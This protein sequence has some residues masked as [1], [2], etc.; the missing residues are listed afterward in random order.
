MDALK[1]LLICFATFIIPMVL[2]FPIFDAIGLHAIGV[3]IY[4]AVVF[5]IF[6]SIGSVN[7]KEKPRK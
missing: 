7:A 1:P 2:I 6:M 3:V 5:V 4:C